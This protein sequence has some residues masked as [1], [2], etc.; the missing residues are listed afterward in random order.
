[1]VVGLLT[2]GE[3][4]EFRAKTIP[5]TPAWAASDFEIAGNP[6]GARPRPGKT[7]AMPACHYRSLLDK[8]FGD[9]APEYASG[10][11]LFGCGLQEAPGDPD[12]N[13][14]TN[15]QLTNF[16]R[17]AQ[18]KLNLRTG[19]L[20]S[21]A[22]RATNDLVVLYSNEGIA[23]CGKYLRKTSDAVDE[24][25]QT[26]ED[27]FKEIYIDPFE[28]ATVPNDVVLWLRQMVKEVIDYQVVRAQDIMQK[29][30]SSFAGATPDRYRAHVANLQGLGGRM[31]QRLN[32]FVTLLT[33][34]AVAPSTAPSHVTA[35]ALRETAQL[36]NGLDIKNADVFISHASEDKSY[37]EPLVEVLKAAG[38]IVW[39]DRLTLEWGDDLRNRIDHGL[40]NCRYGIVV[41]SKAFLA[42]K[43]WTNHEFN[44]L[45][46]LEK[47]G[48]KLILPIW[49]GI[50]AE[51]LLK[52]SPAFASR[53]A[54]DSSSDSYEDIRDSLLRLLGHPAVNRPVAPALLQASQEGETVAD[55]MYYAP[56]GERPAM[57]VRKAA[58]RDDWF[59]LHYVD[60]SVEEGRKPDIAI[61]Y[62]LANKRLTMA[63]YKQQSVFGPGLYSEF[64]L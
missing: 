28:G 24:A 57:Y 40:A 44:G 36:R 10:L 58:D 5:L 59:I 42:G 2:V 33:L 61:K 41:F 46:A 16:G 51:E 23:S 3:D 19:N 62:A 31:Q 34:E 4:V 49:H 38:I 15:D 27:A 21:S 43:K 32:D 55:V 6:L 63:G 64:I 18:I 13:E 47:N 52:Y 20:Y 50:T 8:R 11:S 7:F 30:C 35:A 39:Y 12:M 9:F 53:L 60:G 17:A 45:F 1:V 48:R 22:I 54:K 14:Q 37:V 56:S 25:F 26:I 29:L